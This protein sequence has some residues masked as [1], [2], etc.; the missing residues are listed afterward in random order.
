MS[1]PSIRLVLIFLI[2]FLAGSGQAEP[3][4]V[5]F[6]DSTTAPRGNL[7]VFAHHLSEEKFSGET[8]RIVNAGVPGHN[9]DHARARFEKDVLAERPDAV[10]IQF[11][12][13]DAAIDVWKKPPATESRVALEVYRANLEH[14][15]ERLQ[16]EGVP[17]VLMTPNPLRWTEKM[18][19]MYGE[20][21]YDPDDE[22]GFDQPVRR[23]AAEVRKIASKKKI[24]LVDIHRIF[25]ERET[26]A[27]LLDGIHP[28]ADGHAV[29]AG[30]LAPVLE[31]ALLAAAQ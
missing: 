27:L 10:V 2:C 31:T 15:I 19:G 24:P 26:R 22:L 29:V 5:L 4:I 14:F 23:Y 6:G 11:G 20:P 28:N 18:R 17:V 9:T 30:A 8:A 12:I 21:P 7:K 13:N 3:T 16:R 1:L 25:S